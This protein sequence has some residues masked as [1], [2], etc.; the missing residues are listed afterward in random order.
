MKIMICG[1]MSFAK[2]MLELQKHLQNFGHAVEVPCDTDLHI[3]NPD[4]IDQLEE[5]REHVIEN[6]ILRKCFDLLAGSDAV[7][8]LNLPK[9]GIEGYVGT[10]SLMELGL[11]Y[12]LKKKIYLMYPCPDPKEYRWAHEVAVIR[13]EI[14]NGDIEPLRLNV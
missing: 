8:F 12:Y 9:N 2:E 6:N 5:N 3:E 14:L 11:A 1:S 10:S 13:P 4:L 7:I